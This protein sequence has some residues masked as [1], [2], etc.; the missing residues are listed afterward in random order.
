MRWAVQPWAGL[1]GREVTAPAGLADT[2]PGRAT[3]TCPGMRRMTERRPLAEWQR[4]GVR[5]TSSTDLPQVDIEGSLVAID[6]RTFLVYD[7]YDAL[8]RYNCIHRYA[9]TVAMFAEQLR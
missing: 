9:L 4:L 7:N 5:R 2:V 1:R 8:M 6:G 3:G